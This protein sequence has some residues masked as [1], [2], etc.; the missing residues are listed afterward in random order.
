MYTVYDIYTMYVYT[1][2]CKHNAPDA[3][4]IV[5]AHAGCYCTRA[6]ANGL[7]QHNYI[8]IID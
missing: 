2:Q 8:C 1:V 5:T 3:L 7:H 4:C 6:H